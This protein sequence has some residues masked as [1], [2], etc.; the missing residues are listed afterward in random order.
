MESRVILIQNF[1]VQWMLENTGYWVTGCMDVLS[2]T[3]C[4]YALGCMGELGNAGRMGELGEP[5][6]T[7]DLGVPVCTG[8]LEDFGCVDD[9]AETPSRRG[10]FALT[11]ETAN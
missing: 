5:G 11:W 9:L 3:G 8:S 4:K 1:R 6:C 2:N 7:V 10:C